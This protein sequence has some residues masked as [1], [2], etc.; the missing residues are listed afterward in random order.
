MQHL[1]TSINEP[2][3]NLMGAT[4]LVFSIMIHSP[5]YFSATRCYIKNVHVIVT[6]SM[7]YG[8]RVEY[9]IFSQFDIA[10]IRNPQI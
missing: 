3:N 5:D 7:R 2:T 1:Q 9:F 10:L 4:I 8:Y 6:H